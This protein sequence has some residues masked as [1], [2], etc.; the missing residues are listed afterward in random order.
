MSAIII[1]C[2]NRDNKKY[3]GICERQFEHYIERRLCQSC[4]KHNVK[5][6][7]LLKTR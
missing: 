4:K 7:A 3:K 2:F 6:S 5:A 1:K